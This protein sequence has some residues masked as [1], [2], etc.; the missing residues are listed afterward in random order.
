[1]IKCIN[2][3][4][5]LSLVVDLRTNFWQFIQGIHSFIQL[6][7]EFQLYSRNYS[8]YWRCRCEQDRLWRPHCRDIKHM[9]T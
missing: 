7:I 6:R 9:K 5:Q 3:Y 2:C 1:M 8:R 4:H